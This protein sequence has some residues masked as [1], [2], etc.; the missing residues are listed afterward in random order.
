MNMTHRRFVPTLLTLILSLLSLGAPSRAQDAP[1]PA[2]PAMPQPI[3]FEQETLP[4]GLKVIYAPLHQAPV[5]HLRVL[6]HVGS[7]DE[8]PDRQGFAHMFEHMM[9]RG[10]AHVKPEQ[11][12]RLI[13]T[14]G[15][16]S[17][18]FTSF[19]ETVYVNTV[20]AEH[21]EMAMYL[22]ADRMASFK[23]DEN[24]YKTERNVVAEEWRIRQNRPYGTMFEDF[25]KNSFTKS[26]YRWTPIGVMEQLQAADVAELQDFFNTYYVPNNAVLVIAGDIDVAKTKE[27]ARK[28]FG[29]I[30]KGPDV[31]RDIPQEPEQ[32]QAK[33]VDVPDRVPL[34]AV[35]IGYH[36]PD[37]KN[38]DKYA[39]GVLG[40][41][42]SS[43][44]SGRLDKELVYGPK[45]GAVEASAGPMVLEDAG[46]FTVDATVMQGRD[47]AAVEKALNDAIALV[48]EKGVTVEELEKAKTNERI[49]LIRGRQTAVQ[50]ASQVG[51]EALFGDD[52]GRVNEEL[53]KIQAITAADV[54]AV[55]KKYL[56]PERA[57]TLHIIPDPTGAATAKAVASAQKAAEA[58]VVAKRE[59]KPRDVKFPEGYPTE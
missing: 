28:Y 40:D 55:A 57:T 2:A 37:Y 38:D 32:T 53:K 33:V 13:G 56:R 21:L 11:H 50:L 18:A 6:Y 5:V 34:P 41:I 54:Q 23:V 20:P 49:G 30:P 43:G 29:W 51:D 44:R 1:K 10:S 24:I 35:L 45:P 14:V 59:I 17:N 47:P 12:M 25:L 9:F 46:V 16:I 7:K 31:K 26:S 3:E 19:D 15:G 52:P 42:L 39:L 27:M 36:L 4:N 22:E 8:R 58:P 48:V